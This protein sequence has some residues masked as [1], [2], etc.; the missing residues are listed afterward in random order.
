MIRNVLLRR[1]P[2]GEI[3]IHCVMTLVDDGNIAAAADLAE[4][5]RPSVLMGIH[6]ASSGVT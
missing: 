1:V 6:T 2:H 3:R 4:G 5:H